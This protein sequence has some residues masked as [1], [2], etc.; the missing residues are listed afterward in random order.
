MRHFHKLG[1][2]HHCP[3]INVEKLW[4]LFPEGTYDSAKAQAGKAPVL[5][6]TDSGFFKVLGKG[7]LP[8]MP[9]IVKAKYFSKDAEKK[10]KAAGGAC[11]LTA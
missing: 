6:V 9:I 10:I 8:D 5:D 11:L 7:R 3:T 2:P 1:N 4:A